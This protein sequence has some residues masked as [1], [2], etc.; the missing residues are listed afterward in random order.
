MNTHTQC[1]SNMKGPDGKPPVFV[2]EPLW[3][4]CLQGDVTQSGEMNPDSP[5]G[6]NQTAP[7]G[8][9]AADGLG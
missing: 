6:F 9:G 3:L 1:Y 5:S 7:A 8:S 4:P 2:L